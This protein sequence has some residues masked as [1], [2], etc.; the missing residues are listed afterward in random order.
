MFALVS[1]A[2]LSP[3]HFYARTLI[4]TT[5]TTSKPRLAASS[6]LNSAPLIWSFKY[7]TRKNAVTLVE[8][9]PSRCADL[10]A[11]GEVDVALIPA[12]EYQRV[13]D[14][15]VIP[16]VC[17]ASRAEVR[18]VI[19]VSRFDGL[20][21]VRTVAL[22]E[23][24]RTSAAL[25]KI[26]FQEFLRSEPEWIAAKPNLQQMLVSN[27]AALLIGDP[28]MTFPRQ[29]LKVFDMAG[30]WRKY[31]DLGFVFA[32]W[33]AGPH[34]SSTGRTIDFAGACAE[35]LARTE[36]IIDFYQPFLG[37]PREELK[38]YL[39]ENISFSLDD[40]LRAGLELFYNLAYKHN[41]IPALKPLK[42]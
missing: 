33:A 26:I 32:L 27:D 18:S 12:I 34:A 19:L 1:L 40:E 10:L 25:V 2:S 29:G 13:P 4:G 37:L 31:T 7:G 21:D 39:E 38:E 16:N 11:R 36:E 24:S 23:S 15:H 20:E 14:L 8:A 5:D 22:D 42:M 6:Y 41:L 35:G 3:N 28:G 30:L 17:V 9:V